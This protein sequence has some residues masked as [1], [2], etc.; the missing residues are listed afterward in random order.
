[1]PR[2]TG[3]W[4]WRKLA[5]RRWDW[6]VSKNK[7]ESGGPFPGPAPHGLAKASQIGPESN[8]TTTTMNSLLNLHD[9]N[10]RFHRWLLAAFTIAISGFAA[11]PARLHAAD[12][13]VSNVV[14]AQQAGTKLVDISFDVSDAD[15]DTLA[16]SVQVSDDSG[17][18]FAVPVTALTGDTSVAATPAVSSHTLVWDASVDFNQQFNATMIVRVIADD[19]SAPGQPP[20]GMVFIPA[21][22]FVMGRQAYVGEPDELPVHTVTVSAFYLDQFEVTKALWDDVRTYADANSYTFG[23]PGLAQG[24]FHPVHSMNW[25]D[26]VKWC[27]A[28]SEK[29]G[30]TPVYYT[31]AGFTTVYRSGEGTAPFANW[32]AN[33]F[34]LPTEAEWE[35]AARG[36]LV[37]N[38]FSWGNSVEGGDANYFESGDPFATPSTFADTT[39]VGFYDGG[40]IPVG[41]NRAN[42]YGLY[43]MVGNVCEWCWDWYD[44]NYYASS[45]ATDP[46]GGTPASGLRVVRGGSWGHGTDT[47]RCASRSLHNPLSATRIWGL[48]SARGL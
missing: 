13:V 22:D 41:P 21:G 33:G 40:Q 38:V 14:S 36:T 47:I 46:R 31:D 1:M 12:P 27:N 23:N 37:G 17:T 25:Y 26:A 5:R 44:E 48:R 42:G 35:K 30:I 10:A 4:D 15:S 32:S 9:L 29:E 8:M 43:D 24:A 20:A 34:R 45:P 39:P 3:S 11:A 2:A 6:G 19:G 18:T 7:L 16:I 28:R